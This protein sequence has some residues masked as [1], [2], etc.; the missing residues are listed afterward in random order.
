MPTCVHFPDDPNAKC[1]ICK[2]KPAPTPVFGEPSGF[3]EQGQAGVTQAEHYGT[4]KDCGSTIE[5]GDDIKYSE[6]H[7]GWVHAEVCS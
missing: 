2:P 6:R 4:C 3:A 1:T 7:K 5:P